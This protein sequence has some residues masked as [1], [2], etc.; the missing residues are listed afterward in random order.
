MW[1]IMQ[2]IY[3]QW[4]TFASSLSFIQTWNTILNSKSGDVQGEKR[5]LVKCIMTV[6][7]VLA[8][9][10]ERKLLSLAQKKKF[11]RMDYYAKARYSTFP[12]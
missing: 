8:E 5:I 1:R 7:W 9:D 6:M 11:G 3:V 12:L 2:F 10:F 4:K